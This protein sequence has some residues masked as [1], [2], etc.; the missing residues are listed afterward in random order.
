MSLPHKIIF[1]SAGQSGFM[2]YRLTRLRFCPA[3]SLSR[4]TF[5][6]STSARWLGGRSCPSRRRGLSAQVQMDTILERR[7]PSRPLTF[8]PSRRT[9]SRG[10]TK[11]AR[12]S[13]RGKKRRKKIFSYFLSCC[14]C[15][16]L[17]PLRLFLE[18]LGVVFVAVA[19]A[20]YYCYGFYR[21]W[22][23]ELI[24]LH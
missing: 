2:F 20:S 24:L 21:C 4:S 6:G 7:V 11:S 5:R 23:C 15:C 17:L 8:R 18:L 14:W 9:R 3:P 13:G 16:Q 10:R 19:S 1:Y 22:C 12:R